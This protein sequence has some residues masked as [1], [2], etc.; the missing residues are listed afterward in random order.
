MT[1]TY[2]IRMRLMP[3][4]S[5][6]HD[7]TRLS[8]GAGLLFLLVAGGLCM[9]IPGDWNVVASLIKT[10]LCLLLGTTGLTLLLA[11]NRHSEVQMRA[12][13]SEI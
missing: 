8:R 9:T 6:L 3:R 4:R 2:S 1:E 12:V 7:A 5:G 11:P 13:L 10:G